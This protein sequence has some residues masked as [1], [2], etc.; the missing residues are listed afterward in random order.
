MQAYIALIRIH[1]RL[2]FREKNVLFFTYGFPLIF[3]IGLGQLSGARGGGLG[4]RLLSMVLMIGI[5]GNGLF[6][7]GL[8]AVSE[9]EANIL[10]RYKVTP[11]SPAPLLVASMVTGWLLYIPSATLMIALSHYVY[12]MPWPTQIGALVVVL[13]LGCFAFRAIGLIVAS[14]A[15]TMAEATIVTQIL[16]MPM[17]LLSGATIPISIMPFYAQIVGQ[18]LPASYLNTGIQDAL[19]RSHGWRA[20]AGP[21]AALVLSTVVAL[22]VSMKLFRWEKEEKISARGKAWAIVVFLPFLVLG[23]REAYTREHINDSKLLDREIRRKQTRLIRNVRVVIGDGRTVERGA[24]L[25]RDGKIA[26]VYEGDGP[27]PDS[28]NADPVEAAGKTII[29]GLIDAHV[30]LGAPGG[31]LETQGDY[32]AQK[33]IRRALASYLYSGVVAVKSVGDFTGEVLKARAAVNSGLHAGAELFVCGPLF[34]APDGHGTEYFKYAPPWIKQM[35][36]AEFVRVPRTADEARRQVDELHK[37][38]VNGI[39]AILE[40]GSAGI[41]YPRMDLSV[42]QA[43]AQQATAGGLPLAVHTGDSRDIA[44]ALAVGAR[45]IEHGSMRDR[46][47]DE[48]FAR[49]KERGVYYD[50]TLSVGE[51]FSDLRNGKMD[52]LDGTLVQQV[53]PKGMVASTRKSFASEQS[54]PWRDQ[55]S[56]YPIDLAAAMDNLLRAW[57]AGVT[58]VAGTDS[59]NPL[60]VHGPAVHRELQLWV[61][62]GV[63]A[64]VALQAATHNAAILLGIGNRVGLIREGFEASLLILDGNPLTDIAATERISAVFLK[65]ERVD[66]AGLFDQK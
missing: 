50:P 27:D 3:F 52:L 12:G 58:L 9:R 15:N 30:H 21:A 66:R 45:G 48:L 14:V 7:A 55:L 62:A 18:F 17:L 44:D 8:R 65:G 41:V 29:P 57:K 32:D 43:V 5:L 1:L 20:S 26:K 19:L 6:G 60:L 4:A 13:T 59:G 36:E 34:T 11:I 23:V 40:A 38:G 49:M 42:L 51:A 16:Y 10:R 46:V 28:L 63:P 33:L 54:R 31:A 56:K 39:K 37:Q 22:W 2:A 61:K 25:L 53:A 24:V 64:P 47:P 35:S